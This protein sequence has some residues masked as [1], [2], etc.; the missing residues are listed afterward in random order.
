MEPMRSSPIVAARALPP[1][2][3]SAADGITV[4]TPYFA[5]KTP[6]RQAELDLCLRQNLACA[7]LGRLVLMID[8]GHVPP[9]E[10]PKL[11]IHRMDGRPSYLH[12]WQLTEAL[13]DGHVSILAN[14]DI[15]FDE[16]LPRVK[17][18]LAGPRRFL[19]LSRHEKVG[20]GLQP[21]AN[22]KWS[23][24]VWGVRAGQALAPSLRQALNVPLGVPRCDNKIAYLFA[25]HGW[26]VHNPMQDLRS[27]HVHETQQRHY[28]KKTDTTVMG[29][30]AYVHPSP[31]LAD[32][33]QV[34]LEVW[35]RNAG[36]V[37]GVKLNSSLD[38]WLAEAEA[39]AGQ[40]PAL[41][42]PGA[43][44]VPAPATVPQP[45]PVP[46]LVRPV[47]ERQTLPAIQAVGDVRLVQRAMREGALVFSAGHRF[48]V[49]RSADGCMAVDSL[50]PA[51]AQWL[52]AALQG[53][54]DLTSQPEALLAAFVPPVA[55][56]RPLRIG[57][58]PRDKADVQFWQY[59]AATE[60]QA[61]E[62]HLATAVGSNLDPANRLVHTYLA[63]PWATY[64]DKKHLPDEVVR[65]CGPRLAGLAALAR[66][67]GFALRVHTVCQQ[68]HWRRL[69]DTFCQIGI[70][71]LHLSHA[72]HSID[73]RREGW[74]FKV[75][76]WPLFAPNIEVPER[77]AG[78][79]VGKAVADKR[80]LASFIG[81]H[82]PHYRSDVRLQL[83]EA[84]QAA[85][86]SDILVDLGKE[87]HFNKLVYQEQVQHKPLAEADAQQVAAAAQRYNEVLS[88]SVFSLCPEG[89]GPNTL[90][91][92][93]S[94]AVGAIPVVI[95]KDWT[96]PDSHADGLSLHQC[97][98][99]TDQPIDPTLFARLAAIP[100]ETKQEMQLAG[101]QAYAAFRQ[102]LA[103]PAA[104]PADRRCVGQT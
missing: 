86:R 75:H 15:Y 91:I 53:Q 16:T 51:A 71:D 73:P 104:A 88:D 6:E 7:A 87:W 61:F 58:R 95:A 90:R 74:P 50:S 69:A 30:V 1:G 83:A 19:A 85:A 8:D 45:V 57:L 72:E 63:L 76:S 96:P 26:A 37:L 29:G 89:A 94:L 92:W 32:A 31:S 98:L 41:V 4:F 25:V 5:A 3:G 34:E 66:Q 78:L 102:R 81:A 97:A 68:I 36:A 38:R 43:L 59:P 44:A 17:T 21:H 77:R 46:A 65:L 39:G 33:S 54:A 20:D 82:M 9:L 27:V 60:R 18:A 48:K 67:L 28:D 47:V 100:L 11:Q 99:F 52:P 80:Y 49:Y 23:Q 103:F 42:S 79:L 24:D 56:T 35:V 62:N 93:E 2:A 13:A 14:S 84:A 55:D 40:V 10:H 12:W 101:L 70:T 22:P 64:I